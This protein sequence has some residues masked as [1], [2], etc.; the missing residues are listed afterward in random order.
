MSVR[1]CGIVI[2][3]LG[4]TLNTFI[5][6]K[7]ATVFPTLN[8]DYNLELNSALFNVKPQKKPVNKLWI[9]QDSIE[10][11]NQ[12]SGYSNV[13]GSIYIVPQVVPRDVFLAIN[14]SKILEYETVY[15]RNFQDKE[16]YVKT[17]EDFIIKTETK[18][19]YVNTKELQ[20][21][22]NPEK[23]FSS[24]SFFVK[25][26]KDKD[27]SKGEG[28]IKGFNFIA[29]KG[30]YVELSLDFVKED[31]SIDTITGLPD[32]LIFKGGKIR[33]TP[34]L[35]GEYMFNINISDGS[36]IECKITIPQLIRLL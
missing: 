3:L 25:G 22:I 10:L 19:F 28:V 34:T 16:F 36:V 31:M 12:N 9:E 14:E 1:D 17:P 13:R 26:E 11:K 27:E 35:S 7:C 21:I 2:S 8:I 23:E 6:N 29:Q 4:D 30:T 33:G 18:S 5:K 32:G 15:S 20:K 24:V